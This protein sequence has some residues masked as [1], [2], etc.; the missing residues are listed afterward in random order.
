MQQKEGRYT[1]S[2]SCSVLTHLNHTYLVLPSSHV[3]RY[4]RSYFLQMQH[5]P[6]G[7]LTAIC[8]EDTPCKKVWYK[9]FDV[10]LHNSG[11]V[12]VKAWSV[13]YF[14]PDL[15]ANGETRLKQMSFRDP[16][17]FGLTKGVNLFYTFKCF[18][19]SGCTASAICYNWPWSNINVRS[20][21]LRSTGIVERK[22]ASVEAKNLCY[23]T[24]L[25]KTS[26][27][28]HKTDF[29]GY[30]IGAPVSSTRNNPCWAWMEA[31]KML[32]ILRECDL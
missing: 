26:S 23:A 11:A 1:P 2:V 9:W 6:S 28:P 22:H 21:T 5:C 30:K 8:S 31:Q 14:N 20:Y 10:L 19:W 4:Q 32:L 17:R 27:L 25:S 18:K 12:L 29:T 15:R 24:T 13:L 3:T 7:C 16:F